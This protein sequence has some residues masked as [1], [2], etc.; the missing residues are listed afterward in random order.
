M[1]N[2]LP[3]ETYSADPFAFICDLVIPSAHG[4]ARFGDVMADF[5]RKRFE[6][7]CPS[8][9][10]LARGEKPPIG[11]FW[12]EAT[13]GASK[14]SDLAC[15]FLWL[16]AFT[17]RPLACQIGAA[18]ADQADEL[19]KAAKG[20]LAENIWLSGR[21]EIQS[22]R[23]ICEATQSEAE[24]ISCDV[25]G[26]HGARPDL[27]VLNEVHA[28]TKWEFAQNLLD[29][30]S[31]VPAGIVVC[32]TN[33]GFIGSEAYK[34]RE[35]AR[36]SDRWSYHELA[37]PAPWLDA[38]ELEEAKRRNQ[39]E[40]FNRLFWGRWSTGTG[41]A[42]SSDDV[43]A[44]I[45]LT[46][47]HDWRMCEAYLAALDLSQTRD[48][49]SLIVL[50]IDSQLR[51][52]TLAQVR[53]WNPELCGGRVSLSEVEAEIW[54]LH[55]SV[56]L[57]GVVYDPWQAEQM[58][59]N[60]SARGVCMLRWDT[61]PANLDLMARALLNA[62]RERMIAIWR[63]ESLMSDLFELNLI[64]RDSG[65]RLASRR[66]KRGHSDNAFALASGLPT[67]L[68]WLCQLIQERDSE[69]DYEPSYPWDRFHPAYS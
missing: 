21:V 38:A 47:P 9:L 41:N 12:W 14:D 64:E 29:N 31:K 35:L 27:L 68:H 30:A 49:T 33:A 51:R 7:L 1:S 22:W 66:G 45:T 50:G 40:R 46:G 37:C 62:F 53:E 6:A 42:L 10:S 69:V 19:R 54:R 48:R 36:T 13:K 15:C 52:L 23:L 65:Y 17:S 55:C 20:I 24:I 57:N 18:D 60:L 26:S 16:L 59:A 63:H 2:Q 8:L 11:R 28:I 5:Q 3:I 61:T 56:G 34:L 39:P 44:A 4:V 67:A 25:A 32:A 58:A 43:E